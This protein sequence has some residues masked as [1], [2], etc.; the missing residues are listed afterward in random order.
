MIAWI[1]CCSASACD[2]GQQVRFHTPLLSNKVCLALM[3]F[4]PG[5]AGIFILLFCNLQL[6]KDRQMLYAG[7]EIT[8]WPIAR[9]LL[10]ALC[11]IGIVVH[12]ALG[13]LDYIAQ[14]IQFFTFSPYK[15][16]RRQKTP[17]GIRVTPRRDLECAIPN[18]PPGFPR[19]TRLCEQSFASPRLLFHTWRRVARCVLCMFM[20]HVSSK[21]LALD[22]IL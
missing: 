11:R 6:P 20:R 14:D 4:R 22:Y 17:V 15:K 16:T 12:L 8:I 9:C 3:F 21:L 7:R 19:P 10:E 18:S 5:G 2:I 13:S 1:N